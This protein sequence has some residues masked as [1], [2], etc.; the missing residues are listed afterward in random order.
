MTVAIPEWTKEGVL[1]P[2][3]QDPLSMDRSPYQVSL[4]DVVGRFATNTKRREI[5]EGFLR[6]R[7]VLHEAGL[8]AGFQWIDGSFAEHVE[9]LQQRVPE[10]IDVVTFYRRPTGVLPPALL[11]RLVR[12]FSRDTETR[13]HILAEFKVDGYPVDLALPAP[14]LVEKATYWY[15][16]WS[17]RR[18][19]SWKGYL[20][21]SLAPEEDGEAMKLLADHRQEVT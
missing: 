15:G 1:P 18:D 8:V 20:E 11:E 12:L 21:L 5:L 9:S 10:D 7:A 13:E 19:R 17:H 6:Y 4:L 3:G 16:L 2:T 14:V